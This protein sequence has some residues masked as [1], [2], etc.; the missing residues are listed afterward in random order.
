MIFS[1]LRTIQLNPWPGITRFGVHCSHSQ[2]SLS[3][4]LPHWN[5]KIQQITPWKPMTQLKCWILEAVI[6]MTSTKQWL[7]GECPP[8]GWIEFGKMMSSTVRYPVAHLDAWHVFSAVVDLWDLRGT[9]YIRWHQSWKYVDVDE[10]KVQFWYLL[11]VP[12]PWACQNDN[13]LDSS[14]QNCDPPASLLIMAWECEELQL[15]S[16]HV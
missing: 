13:V 4:I 3:Q 14:S 6:K 15:K 5:H 10:V 12:C 11:P 8:I 2:K 16:T 9:G 7:K 1:W